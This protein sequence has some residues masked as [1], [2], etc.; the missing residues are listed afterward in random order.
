MSFGPNF[1]YDLPSHDLAPPQIPV[2]R[3]RYLDGQNEEKLVN[4]LAREYMI[5]E[6]PARSK[7]WEAVR[8]TNSQTSQYTVA[9]HNFI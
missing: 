6:M 2:H 4:L 3:I 8:F 1:L 7:Y 9:L 5:V